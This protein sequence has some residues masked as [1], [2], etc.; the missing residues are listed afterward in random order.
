LAAPDPTSARAD[1][2]PVGP[3]SGAAALERSPARLKLKRFAEALGQQ[4]HLMSVRDGVIGALPLIL[5]GSIF[6]LC[7]Q[8]PT[9]ALQAK[10]APYAPT[11]LIPYRMLGGVLALYVCFGCAYSL[12]KRYALDPLTSALTAVATYLVALT[13]LPLADKAAGVGLPFARL[14]AGGMFGALALAIL[15]VEVTRFFD[16]RRWTIQL[17]GG[18]PD[19]IIKSFAAL[20][21]CC[22]SI[23]IAWAVVH[24]VHFDVIGAAASLARP[25]VHAGNTLPAALAVVAIDSGMW[26]IGVHGYAVL[27][28]FK[29]V[30]LQMLVE[31]MN[32]AAAGLHPPNVGVQ[33]M[34]MW[35]VWQGGSGS[36]LAVA[37]WL[38]RAKSASLRS[39][40][41]L[42]ALP[43]IF[44][45]N[46][47]LLF[48]LPMVL[49]GALAI[50]FLLAPLCTATTAWCAFHFDWVARPRLEVIWT[51]PSP[52]GAYLTTG[53]DWRAVVLELFNLALTFAIYAPFLRRYDR[54]ILAQE[55]AAPAPE[56]ATVPEI[57]T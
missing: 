32:A 18:A 30:W 24:V 21:P 36:T 22:V 55:Q 3:G 15:A 46:E 11:L 4:P 23:V 37:L 16:R 43:A 26:L 38:L 53:G 44:N 50:P 42:A 47:P 13:P 48:G 45:I 6:L 10:V 35:F 25:L 54:K 14:G 20:I 29:P 39:V 52:V 5:V 12:A 7:A 9:A 34:F 28:A 40:G 1:S 17:P 56:K 33:E 51:I 57:A 27:A 31:N 8:P 2:E 41:K 49:N 19:V